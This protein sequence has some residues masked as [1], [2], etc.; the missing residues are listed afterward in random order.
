MLERPGERV[1]LRLCCRQCGTGGRERGLR[2]IAPVRRGRPAF[3][4]LGPPSFSVGQRSRRGGGFRFGFLAGSNLF[5]S[6]AQRFELLRK[7]GPLLLRPRQL[8]SRRLKRGFSDSAFGAH[9]RLPRE[10]FR[11][12]TLG[13]PRR[14]FGA[15][16]LGGEARR[17]SFGVLQA[18]LDRAALL[19]QLFDRL[20]GVAL[21]GF[22]PRDVAGKRHL[23]PLEL[24]QPP[25]DRVAPRARCRE[26]VCQLMP[27]LARFVE[28]VALF[29]QQSVGALLRG[30][31]LDDD[32]LD[33]CHFLGRGCCFGICGFRGS[34]GLDPAGMKQPCL[35]GADL[36]GELAVALGGAR[37]APQLRRALF[38]LAK[39]FAEPRK[40]GLRRAEL[41]L[42]VL[43]PRV[44]A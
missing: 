20:G 25:G 8:G 9:C 35:D 40:I 18:L 33:S 21:Q 39:D 6:T 10:Q 17:M 36:V 34:F 22:L 42:G 5:R 12:R 1:V 19:I 29:G 41:L 37:L 23:E 7:L 43:A 28:R 32:G 44:Q 13:L 11:K 15:C 26:L 27:L 14:R 16:Q 38:L 3:F 24:G 4:R 31:R 30:L 2:R